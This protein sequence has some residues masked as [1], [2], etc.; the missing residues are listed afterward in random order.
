MAESVDAT[1]LKS[2]VRKDV[3]VRVSLWAPYNL[4]KLDLF[5]SSV[6]LKHINIPIKNQ[7]IAS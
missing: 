6:I 5:L 2:V 3:G 1:D 7:S 4:S